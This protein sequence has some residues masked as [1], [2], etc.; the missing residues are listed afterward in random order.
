MR[1]GVQLVPKSIQFTFP[2][3]FLNV[4]YLRIV[5]SQLWIWKLS[6]CNYSWL[7]TTPPLSSPLVKE[8]EYSL[9]SAP[10]RCVLAVEVIQTTDPRFAEV[11]TLFPE[12]DMENT[13]KKN[14]YVKIT[15]QPASKALRFRYE[16][17]GR[18]AGS[19]PGVNSTP[20]NKTF[21]TIQVKLKFLSQ[22]CCP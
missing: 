13:R 15:E 3:Y 8:N 20:E 7:D 18:S 10:H 5:R 9:L 21:P 14:V 2:V 1:N 17:E 19:I 11:S 22:A 6:H 12:T 16:C 4:V